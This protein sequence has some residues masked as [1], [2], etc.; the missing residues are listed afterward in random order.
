M[1]QGNVLATGRQ[2]A[3]VQSMLQRRTAEIVA[4]RGLRHGSWENR[5]G[6]GGAAYC[7]LE[8]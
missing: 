7:P 1:M 4:G 3:N 8:P 5:L 6:R 2:S